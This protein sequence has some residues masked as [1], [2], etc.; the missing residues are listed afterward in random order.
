MY[1]LYSYRMVRGIPCG[2]L[3]YCRKLLCA[4]FPWIYKRGRVHRMPSHGC[5][6]I[7]I[8]I[9]I[10]HPHASFLF[11][12]FSL[13]DRMRGF[14]QLPMAYLDIFT[15]YLGRNIDRMPF[16]PGVRGPQLVTCNYRR[17]LVHVSV[18]K[19]RGRDNGERKVA[20]GG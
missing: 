19:G 5:Q 1:V 10:S 20:K 18:A 13:S 7:R 9:A 12:F 3:E 17:R 4:S 6:I 11:L 15:S 14:C 2:L 16:S 8:H